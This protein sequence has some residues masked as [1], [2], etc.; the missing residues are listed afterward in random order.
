MTVEDLIDE[1]IRHND[2]TEV[3]VYYNEVEACMPISEVSYSI[4]V[5]DGKKTTVVVLFVKK[6]QI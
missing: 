4:N 2:D 3:I 6:D 5:I 1:L